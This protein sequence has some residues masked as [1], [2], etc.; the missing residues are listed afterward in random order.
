MH[1][2]KTDC[3][4][5]DL[6]PLD[7]SVHLKVS[8][9]KTMLKVLLP[10]EADVV[11]MVDHHDIRIDPCMNQ[12]YFPRQQFV[13]LISMKL[14]FHDKETGLSV[15]RTQDD[16]SHLGTTWRVAVWPTATTTLAISMPMVSAEHLK[17]NLDESYRSLTLALKALNN[18]VQSNSRPIW[19][20]GGRTRG[21]TAACRSFCQRKD[22][23]LIQSTCCVLHSQNPT[24]VCTSRTGQPSDTTTSELEC[25]VQHLDDAHSVLYQ[26]LGL[27]STRFCRHC[28]PTMGKNTSLCTTRGKFPCRYC[29]ST[30]HTG[31]THL[32]DASHLRNDQVAVFAHC[33]DDSRLYVPMVSGTPCA[34]RKATAV[35]PCQSGFSRNFTVLV[36]KSI[37]EKSTI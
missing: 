29:K 17:P 10:K 25:G 2:I 31:R 18:L 16:V 3:R 14:W 7:S 33:N 26:R 9:L 34:L 19:Q 4:G 23:M 27:C 35:F 20:R 22:G 15:V 6:I 8:V 24:P 12:C 30:K 21:L 36:G 37:T 11:H 1:L 5:H 13:N 32:H 28:K